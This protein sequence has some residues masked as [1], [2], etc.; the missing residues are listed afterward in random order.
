VDRFLQYLF[1]GLSQGSIY[2]LL[3]L[4]LV[5]IY[6]GSGQFNFA[7]GEIAMFSAFVASVEVWVASM[8]Q[9]TTF[10]E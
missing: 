10:R 9:P 4:G 3:A 5:T 6:R 7:Q 2:A 8:D 1:D